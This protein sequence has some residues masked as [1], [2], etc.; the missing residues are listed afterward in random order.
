MWEDLL[1][2]SQY[3]TKKVKEKNIKQKNQT[4]SLIQEN[5]LRE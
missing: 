3:A 5:K 4:V 2:N 1:V